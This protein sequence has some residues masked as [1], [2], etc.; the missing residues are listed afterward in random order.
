MI[1]DVHT[2]LI[3]Y[4]TEMSDKIK[5]DLRRCR[6]ESKWAYGEDDYAA[7]SAA[8]DR[9]FVFGL[10][11]RATGWFSDNARVAAFADKDPKRYVFVAAIDPLDPDYMD[12][13]EHS[14]K[15]LRAKM[16]KLGPIYQGVHP[17]DEKYGRIY[18]YCQKNNLPIITH[19]ATTFA[20]GVPL[21]YA[22]PALMDRVSCEYPELKII[23]AHLGHPWEEE[24]IAAIRKQPNLYADISA[25]YYRPFR[26]YQS[27]RLLEE[28]GAQEKVFFGSD[29]PACTTGD[30]LAG[31]R[32][33]NAV[34]EGSSFPKVSKE[35]V[36]DIINR[37]P[38]AVLGID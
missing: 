32:N 37:D 6:L 12:Q 20:S 38:A 11:A 3:D 8:A 25:L 4:A 24:A 35:I 30:S 2:H 36:E 9:V 27:M 33:V 28:Y 31:I 1:T 21:E 5:S 34:A 15:N 18:S 7:A 17:L 19:M 23:L 14:H 26:F 10:R 16:V 29:Y 22:R 13:L